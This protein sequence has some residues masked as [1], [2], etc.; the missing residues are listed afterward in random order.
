MKKT[1]TREPF[2]FIREMSS[3][4]RPIDIKT[5]SNLIAVGAGIIALAVAA[6]IRLADGDDATAAIIEGVFAGITVFLAWVISREIDPDH[7]RSGLLTLPVA[8]GVYLLLGVAALFSIATVI[9]AA[10]FLNR[11]VGP[12]PKPGDAGVLIG[13]VTLAILFHGHWFLG[14]VVFV[15]LLFETL[16]PD[17]DQ[18]SFLYAGGVALATIVATILTSNLELDWHFDLIPFVVAG[19]AATL[20]VVKLVREPR[21]LQSMCDDGSRVLRWERVIAAQVFVLMAALAGLLF[22]GE[23]GIRAIGSAWAAMAAV[24]AYMIYLV[25]TRQPVPAPPVTYSGRAIRR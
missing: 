24:G 9:V 1:I 21:Y 6:L 22:E 25:A 19:I 17:S 15:A 12:A 2:G 20:F 4:Y 13:V 16:L 10:R 8:F 18:K 3:L 11:S 7:Q 23:E 5:P 14:I